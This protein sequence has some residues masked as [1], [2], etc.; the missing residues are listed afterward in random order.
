MQLVL[1][2]HVTAHKCKY[3][4]LHCFRISDS[5]SWLSSTAHSLWL[6]DIL[7]RKN[8]LGDQLK[9]ACK[10]LHNRQ[11]VSLKEGCIYWLGLW[12]MLMHKGKTKLWENGLHLSNSWCTFSQISL[13]LQKLCSSL[14]QMFGRGIKIHLKWTTELSFFWDIC[15]QMCVCTFK[16]S[17]VLTS[18]DYSRD[19][20]RAG[21]FTEIWLVSPRSLSLWL[22]LKST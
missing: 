14:S 3:L 4:G 11:K 19:F 22:G 18:M 5:P 9:L 10:K 8:S 7:F 20:S 16:N 15:I 13:L 6:C 1:H 21:S 12:H 17:H 2:T